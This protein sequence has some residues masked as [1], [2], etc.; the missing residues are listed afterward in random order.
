MN[1][2]RIR[3]TDDGS[4]T[5]LND[6][7]GETY[8]S[9]F[10]AIQESKHIFINAGLSEVLRGNP[11]SINIL[12]VGTGTGLNVLLTYEY[13][14][15]KDVKIEYTGYEAYPINKSEVAELNYPQLLNI[16]DCLLRLIHSSTDSTLMLSNSF[17]FRNVEEKIE[18]VSLP[19]SKYNL[20][21]FDAF[22][23]DAQP[24]LW[25]PKIFQELYY[26]LASGGLLTT[27]SCKGIVKRS[28]KEAGFK[29]EKL[30]GPPGKREFLR[31]FKY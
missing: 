22:S 20:I 14:K 9:S 30:P 28:L 7:I 16:N 18:N 31:A 12:E 13:I 8:H 3:I 1:E 5:I 19:K 24:E 27:Y 23:P 25:T 6:H 4:V 21:Y 10:G 29:I 2:T 11:K 15:G 17:T 26:S